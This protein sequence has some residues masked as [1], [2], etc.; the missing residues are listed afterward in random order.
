MVRGIVL[1]TEQ[2]TIDQWI[3]GLS[4]ALAQLASH[5]AQSR[6]ALERFLIQ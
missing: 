2:I 6:A 4:E 1:K 5:S 3:D